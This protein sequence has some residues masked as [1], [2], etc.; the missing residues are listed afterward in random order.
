MREN[1]SAFNLLR[2]RRKQTRREQTQFQQREENLFLGAVRL[3]TKSQ[4]ILFSE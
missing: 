2:T 3:H 1:I 4:F